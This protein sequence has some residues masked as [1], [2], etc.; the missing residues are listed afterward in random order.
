MAAQEE[1]ISIG[2]DQLQ[3]GLYVTL[4]LNWLD[5]P[6]L[7]SSFKIKN[8]AQLADVRR[9]GLKQIR[10]NPAKSDTRPLPRPPRPIAE[11]APPPPAIS[12]EEAATIARKKAR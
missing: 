3:V 8:Q 11:A 6:F 5:H 4:D 9:L 12:P 10:Y 2:I 1:Y 7:T